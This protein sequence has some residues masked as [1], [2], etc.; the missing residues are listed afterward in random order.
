MRIGGN[1]Q[2]GVIPRFIMKLFPRGHLSHKEMPANCLL[3]SAFAERS[4]ML[5]A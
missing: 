2:E 3:Y 1:S 5:I 4:T